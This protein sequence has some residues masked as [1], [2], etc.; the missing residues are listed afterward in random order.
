[1]KSKLLAASAGE[2]TFVLILDRELRL[3]TSA[4]LDPDQFAEMA[5]PAYWFL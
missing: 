2:R 1:M 3:V 4:S 5:V